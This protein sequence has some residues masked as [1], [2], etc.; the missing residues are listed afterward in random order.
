MR[1]LKIRRDVLFFGV[2]SPYDPNFGLANEN[3][4]KL[5]TRCVWVAKTE[6]M[7]W[8]PHHFKV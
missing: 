4:L 2:G 1:K 8:L 5:A 6:K 7:L 3:D